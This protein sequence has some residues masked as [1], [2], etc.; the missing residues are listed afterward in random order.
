MQ[1]HVRIGIVAALAGRDTDG[2][3]KV[4]DA[5]TDHGLGMGFEH[6]QVHHGIAFKHIPAEAQP[7]AVTEIDLFEGT[8]QK[9]GAFDA[10]SLFQF[11]I[12]QGFKSEVLGRLVLGI[13]HH[14]SL[15]DQDVVHTMVLQHSD[16]VFD[17]PGSRDHP[18]FGQHRLRGPENDVGFHHHPAAGLDPVQA[19]GEFD[20][21]SSADAF[22]AIEND[23][24]H[25]YL[26]SL[27]TSVTSGRQRRLLSFSFVRSKG[28]MELESDTLY[29]I[30][31]DAEEFARHLE[32]STEIG[33]HVAV[34]LTQT[35]FVNHM[36]LRLD[37]SVLL[38]ETKLESDGR[39]IDLHEVFAIRNGTRMRNHLGYWD[40]LKS[41]YFSTTHLP[42]WE[43]R[44]DLKGSLLVNSL[45][46]WSPM[47]MESLEEGYGMDLITTISL[48]CNFTLT[49]VSPLDGSWGDL[50]DEEGSFSGIVGMIQQAKA[51][52]STAGL[53]VSKERNQAIDF[54]LEIFW[55]T[56][57]LHKLRSDG[58][59]INVDVFFD[60]LHLMA[61]TGVAILMVLTATCFFV[62]SQI[63]NVSLHWQNDSEQFGILNSV[64]MVGALLLQRDYPLR[65]NVLS[66]KVLFLT[67]SA[68]TFFIY[69]GYTAILTSTMISKP[70]QATINSFKEILN[71]DYKLA[72]W[73]KTVP[74]SIFRGANEGT[75]KSKL[76][77]DL[78]FYDSAKSAV[79]MLNADPNLLAYE[80]VITFAGESSLTRLHN[81]NEPRRYKSAIALK[82][83]SE[84]L[85]L[86]NYQLTKM[87]Q[88]GLRDYLLLKWSLEEY[89]S[90]EEVDAD[91]TFEPSVVTAAVL[92][93]E[94]LSS[95]FFLLV[96]G[97][98]LSWALV[99]FEYF[100]HKRIMVYEWEKS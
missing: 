92:G 29:V 54:S 5:Q 63:G 31:R 80:S 64:A 77:Q 66:S 56:V 41:K 44:N 15:G 65:K 4:L 87:S 37:S 89:P 33:N 85:G 99:V 71:S 45:L 60:A 57:T 8:R 55:D 82:K 11:W 75:T 83:N 42:M 7:H 61:W 20:G 67:A 28:E 26:V 18:P 38:A 94:N 3:F 35:T 43:R 34:L 90:R 73:E 72:V 68:F 17:D 25:L 86:I 58:R 76:S 53:Y 12:P 40:V 1:I 27:V 84:F 14:G 96:I 95:P 22:N 51:D 48:D 81:F 74:H 100:R 91:S 97:V 79:D 47:V 36:P 6:R 98:L 70:R 21:L 30:L 46:P 69:N 23:E 13:R 16:H 59:I 52:L 62:A 93:Y 78:I 19:A 10:V 2:T 49:T 24:D 32:T 50:L 88:S 39:I 9:I